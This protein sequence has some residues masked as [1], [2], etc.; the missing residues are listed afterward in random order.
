[1]KK[2]NMRYFVFLIL[3]L[4]LSIPFY[5]WGA[6]FPVEGILFDLP[7]SVLMII[8]PFILS[9]IYMWK[10]NRIKGITLLFKSILDIRKANLWSLIFCIACMPL[11]AILTYFTMKLFSLPL[12]TE[13][14]ISYKELP[15][16]IIL[17]F[18]G[19]IPEEFGWTFT[20][21]EP[22]TKV[23][24]PIKSGII[25]GGVW[26]IWHVIPWSWAYPIWWI[27]GMCVLDVL[28][29]TAM[30]YAYMYGGK[31]LF[32]GLAFHAMCNVSMDIF[33]NNG[34]H[35]NTWL[36]SVWMAIILLSVIYFIKRKLKL[37]N[38]EL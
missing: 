29:R 38:T 14:M 6:F 34:S 2:S 7:I 10:E 22:L 31:S 35:M 17:Y 36:F 28:I 24:G 21:T 1:M 23:Y 26:A 9:L 37:P 30:I 18:I 12:P 19:A 11:V 8:I 20:L 3:T 33:P 5:I 25:I 27:I 32:T 16:M 15:L 13:V 4:V